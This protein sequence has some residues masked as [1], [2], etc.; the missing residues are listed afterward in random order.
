[1][2]RYN[3]GYNAD[4]GNRPPG[5]LWGTLPVMTPSPLEH[6]AGKKPPSQPSPRTR[7]RRTALEWPSSSAPHPLS[8]PPPSRLDLIFLLFTP[9]ISPP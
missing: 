3:D 6:E 1:M 2:S 5:T 9:P 4:M 8:A 7:G